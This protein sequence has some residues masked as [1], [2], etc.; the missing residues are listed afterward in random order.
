MAAEQ[1]KLLGK[2]PK[3]FVECTKMLTMIL[4]Q[5]M[6]AEALNGTSAPVQKMTITDPKVC[7]SYLVGTCFFDLFTNT[8]AD[9]GPCPKIH[10]EALKAEY[11][12]A[13]E[14]QKEKW[15]F[16]FDCMRDIGKRIDECNRLIDEYEK[17]LEKTPEE[18]RQVARLVR[19]WKVE[20]GLATFANTVHS[21]KRST[22]SKRTSPSVTSSSEPSSKPTMSARL[23]SKLGET[24]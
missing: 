16:E 7:R 20:I 22:S 6:G 14:E 1:R 24:A 4:E 18:I 11:D 13:S 10:S 12:A 15:G 21:S 23:S 9:K 17:R 8:K 19:L 5:L 2:V 3:K